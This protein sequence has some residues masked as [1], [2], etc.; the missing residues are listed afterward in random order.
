MS[1]WLTPDLRPFVGGTYFPPR[2]HG[3]RPGFGTVLTRIMDQVKTSVYFGSFDQRA[4]LMFVF[5]SAL[6][7][8]AH[9]LH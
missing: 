7:S 2:N 9:F 8:A 6:S 4:V 1:V 3:A 5:L